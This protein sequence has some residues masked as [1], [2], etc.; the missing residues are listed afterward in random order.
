MLNI[1]AAPALALPGVLA[2]LTAE[3][4][5]NNKVGHIPQDWD[6]MIAKGGGSCS[7]G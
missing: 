4:V 7:S 6:V 1:D 2:V 3:D 5:P